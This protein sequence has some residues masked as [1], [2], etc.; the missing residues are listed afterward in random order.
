MKH[1]QPLNIPLLL[2]AINLLTKTVLK[3]VSTCSSLPGVG[4][5]D[6]KRGGGGVGVENSVSEH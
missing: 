6:G 3:M 5:E 1:F 4:L 2:I